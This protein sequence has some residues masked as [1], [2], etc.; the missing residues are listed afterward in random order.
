[1]TNFSTGLSALTTSQRLMDLVGQNLANVNTPGYRRQS[2]ILASLYVGNRAGS[3]VEIQR[4]R[5]TRD[6][7]LE[8]AITRSTSESGNLT[9]Q[10]G[11][12]RQIE[13][14][15]A[16]GEGSLN[17]LLEKFFNQLEQLAGTPSDVSQ[18]RVV[19][20]TASG[21]ANR[22]NGL[23]NDLGRLRDGLDA[24]AR[25]QVG[26]INTL[27]PEIAR[28]NEQIHHQEVQGYPANDLRDRRDQL[29][30]QVAGIANVQTVEMPFG[31]TTV[32]VAGVAIVV[33]N[34]STSLQSGLDAAGNLIVTAAGSSEPLTVTGGRL[35]GTLQTRNQ[36]LPGF[37]NN[38]DTL[39]RT[40]AHKMNQVQATG[41][42]LSGPFS[43]L[44]GSQGVSN[45]TVP[46]SQAGLPFPPQAGSLFVTVT[47]TATGRRTLTE[48]PINPATQS[49]QDIATAISGVSGVQAVVD[50]Q[51]GTL[52][53]LSQAGYT[54]DFTGRVA[55][56][57]TTTAITGTTTVKVGGSY[58]GTV[59]DT[60]TY[61]VVGS[62]TV[63]VTP[64]L[65]MEVRNSAGTLLSTLNV[66]QGY[67][68]GSDL[69]VGNGVTV[70][71]ASGTVNNNDN[72]TVR[73]V[74]QSDTAGLLPALGINSF[75][76]GDRASTLSV[77]SDLAANPDLLAGSLS[78]Q[79]GDGAN[80]R[81]MAAQRDV[82]VMANGTQS[83]REFTSAM[84][85]DAGARVQDVSRRYS[86][87]ELLAERLDAEFQSISGVDPNEEMVALLQFQRSFEMA[88]RY[89]RVVDETLSE[90][91]N[92]VR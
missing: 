81:R 71:L 27:A 17:G 40:F 64:N 34:Q 90:L 36:V 69:Q 54:F 55:T 43:F 30:N 12:L 41:L 16:P 53:V 47:E 25:A 65:R 14:L 63:G 4:V 61:R 26:E 22:F 29:I 38:L 45:P 44:S 9:S 31:Q 59:N 11:T 67:E 32:L 1:M 19:L 46:L 82:K 62:G 56:A 21:L 73:V 70:Q 77:R 58:T 76:V 75:F 52:K 42:G 83:F 88:A 23:A 68:P 85:G 7:I 48:V 57:P 49:L 86:A 66:G 24:Q 80:L 15:L 33:G 92:L 89:I 74:A 78:G 39:A 37:Q 50:P 91:L 13:T 3:G 6:G 60:L 2:A 20:S 28:L 84:V 35:A 72:F 8:A 79:P 51:T 18:R 87:Q 10:L 5:H